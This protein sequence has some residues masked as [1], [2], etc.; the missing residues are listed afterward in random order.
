M[1][2]STDVDGLIPT[3]GNL[4]EAF[5]VFM[6]SVSAVND[7]KIADAKLEFTEEAPFFTFDR[8]RLYVE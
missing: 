7:G 8:S 5:K 6:W 2:E 3:P 4:L 1:I